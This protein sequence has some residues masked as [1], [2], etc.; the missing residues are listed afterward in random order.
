M[1]D[2]DIDFLFSEALADIAVTQVIRPAAVLPEVEAKTVLSEL[3]RRDARANGLWNSTPSVWER[4]DR[5]WVHQHAP[6]EAK[7]I[8]SMHVVYDSP[9]RYEI[10]IYRAVITIHGH[11]QGW[12]VGALSDEALGFA[13]LSLSTCPRTSLN[14]PPPVF[15]RP[16][17]PSSSS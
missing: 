10:T 2:V 7:L 5:P 6:G 11:D 12:D 4:F 14:A 8:G 15:P 13:G 3:G 9:R 16:G 17:N 1:D